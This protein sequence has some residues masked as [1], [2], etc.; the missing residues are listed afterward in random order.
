MTYNIG[1]GRRDFGTQLDSVLDVVRQAQPDVLALQEATSWQDAD[2]HW[3]S[4]VAFLSDVLG[5][6]YHSFF[7]PTITLRQHFFSGKSNFVRAV[8]EDLRDWQFGNA[9]LVR[10]G[11]ARLSTPS[12]PGQPHNLPIFRP[13]QYLGNRDTDP[14]HVI[15][16]RLYEQKI[17]PL[18]IATHLT[19]L[20]GERGK[21][22]DI[23]PGKPDLAQE[24]RCKQVNNLLALLTPYALQ[25][26]EVIFLLGDLNATSD[27]V[28]M[29]H[30]KQSGFIRLD[31]DN[32]DI[33]THKNLCGP[34]DHIL[35]YPGSRLLDYE[36]RV[37]DSPL[38]REA[39][40]HLPVIA[41]VT[42][43]EN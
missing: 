4:S 36:C 11:F 1:G 40:D 31:P 8:F 16:T 30:L 23:A 14:R 3:H 9:L 33:A 32:G 29:D 43:S 41:D 18:I 38:A 12:R 15:L 35:V 26:N 7:G 24:M 27:E 20:K 34:V 28:C 13:T 22:E 37:I 6:D 10:P 2:G 17:A 39:S 5:S 25:R 42:I 19:T 21:P